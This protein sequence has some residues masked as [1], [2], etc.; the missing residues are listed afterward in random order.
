MRVGVAI[1]DDVLAVAKALAVRK[2]CSLGQALSAL[3]RRGFRS[4]KPARK[5]EDDAM[6]AVRADADAI[7]SQDVYRS[8]DDWP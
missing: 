3:A 5:S 1:D 7:T 4:P 2:G 6:F 8:L